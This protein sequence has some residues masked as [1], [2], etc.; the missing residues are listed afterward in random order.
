MIVVETEGVI[1][2]NTDAWVESY[3]VSTSNSSDPESFVN[4]TEGRE[5]KIVS[6]FNPL[7]F[8]LAFQIIKEASPLG[9]NTV[10]EHS[11]RLT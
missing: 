2:G 3:Y 7:F 1:D 8:P 11:K 9:L 6:T 4:Y 5:T 10:D